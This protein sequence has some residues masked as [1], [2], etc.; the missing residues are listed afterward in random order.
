MA[1]NVDYPKGP[2]R[3]LLSTDEQDLATVVEMGR[4][5][6]PEL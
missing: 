3:P 1:I 4:G 2:R 5:T 6:A